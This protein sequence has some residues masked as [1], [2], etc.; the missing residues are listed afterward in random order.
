MPEFEITEYEN[1]ERVWYLDAKDATE[2]QKIFWG[3]TDK[4]AL[5]QTDADDVREN[6]F[7]TF[8]KTGDDTCHST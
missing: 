1:V 8:V 2:A 6:T 7:V 3:Y 4:K 5:Y